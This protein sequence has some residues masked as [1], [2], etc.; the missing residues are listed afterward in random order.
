MDT[1]L[2]HIY[3][4]KSIMDIINFRVEKEALIISLSN[5][6]FLVLVASNHRL[7]LSPPF[8]FS[9]EKGSCKRVIGH[10]RELMGS[11]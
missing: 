4:F 8:L 7:Y 6:Y 5:L 3:I 2:Q 11:T 1:F 10:G 9:D